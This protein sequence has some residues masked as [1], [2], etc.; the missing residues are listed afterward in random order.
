MTPHTI[1]YY[2]KIGIVKP[3]IDEHSGYHLF[4]DKDAKRVRF[5]VEAK[6][7]G[8]TLK[9][10]IQLIEDA[11]KHQSSCPHAR[12]ILQRRII[13][14]RRKLNEL[15]AL[16]HRMEAALMHWRGMPGGVPNGNH[17]CSL[18]ES[19]PLEG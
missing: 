8:F 17:I 6:Q 16:Q 2:M 10:I 12:D 18:I 5:T 15:V 4:S 19:V 14:N 7:L 11:D 3:T 13:E 9:E 1:R